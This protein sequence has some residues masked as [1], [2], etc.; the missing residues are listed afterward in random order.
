MKNTEPE[1]KSY[2]K[3]EWRKLLDNPYLE[4]WLSAHLE[5][6]TAAPRARFIISGM[7]DFI[8]AG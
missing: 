8:E 3:V 7:K 4:E 6:E 1:L 2:L 5:Y